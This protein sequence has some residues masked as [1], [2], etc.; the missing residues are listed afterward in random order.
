[1]PQGHCVDSRV[2]PFHVEIHHTKFQ[3]NP[4]RD[5]GDIVNSNMCTKVEGGGI[6]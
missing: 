4:L 5:G 1:M 3:D 6:K 2:D